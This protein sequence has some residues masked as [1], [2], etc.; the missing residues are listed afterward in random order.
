PELYLSRISRGH[1][2][3]ARTATFGEKQFTGEIDQIDTRV[4][5]TSRSVKVRAVLPNDD[6]LLR[7]GM[8]FA[9]EVKLS[10]R[11]YPAIPELA[12]LWGKGASYVWRI[13]NGTA[14]K[15]PVRIVKRLN[16]TILIDGAIS[17]GDMVVIEGI[18][19]LRPGR[20]VRILSQPPP[21]DKVSR[22]SEAPQ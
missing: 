16:S 22:S 19:R 14:E 10:G 8:S 18:Q 1:K 5:P 21:G 3:L 11:T 9:V 2:I 12:L 20:A 15:V 7:P 6:D 4:E 13:Q 17:E